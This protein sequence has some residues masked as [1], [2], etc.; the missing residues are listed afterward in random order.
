ME[1]HSHDNDS[2]SE[3]EDENLMYM[4][5]NPRYDSTSDV[6]TDYGDAPSGCIFGHRDEDEHKNCIFNH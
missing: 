2:D 3:Y 6:S 1:M 4:L 5:G